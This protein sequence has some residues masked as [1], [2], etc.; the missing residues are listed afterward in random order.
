MFIVVVGSSLF[1][2]DGLLQIL[3]KSIMLSLFYC[4]LVITG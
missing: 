1:V 3:K 4:D 2:F